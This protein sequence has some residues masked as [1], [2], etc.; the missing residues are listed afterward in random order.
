MLII[1]V[2][3]LGG[4]T[5]RILNEWAK[6]H[7]GTQELFHKH[8]T[9][10]Q[11]CFAACAVSIWA[12]PVQSNFAL[13]K[14]TGGLVIKTA[15]L[16]STLTPVGTSE[17]H[18][19]MW[20]TGHRWRQLSGAKTTDSSLQRCKNKVVICRVN[21]ENSTNLKTWH[22][23]WEDLVSFCCRGLSPCPKQRLNTETQ[24]LTKALFPASV[25]GLYANTI[26]E[27]KVN[28]EFL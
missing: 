15:P 8:T 19:K 1:C 4:Q 18:Q 20:L 3:A 2:A 23:Q 14:V 28:V 22:L 16:T 13:W 21:P 6:I 10:I 11:T 7:E 24:H 12:G 25:T 5:Q 9:D 26:T 27:T 17:L